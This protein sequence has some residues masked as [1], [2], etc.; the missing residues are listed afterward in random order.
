MARE[1]LRGAVRDLHDR[2]NRVLREQ[3]IQTLTEKLKSR[4]RV[5]GLD[6]ADLLD[7]ELNGA[8]SRTTI[9][10]LGALLVSDER[11]SLAAKMVDGVI[12]RYLEANPE[13]VEEE[14]A[15]L[16]VQEPD[17]CDVARDAAIEASL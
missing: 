8:R 12:S 17:P 14:V 15:E 13:V 11:E 3:A 9:A 4:G 10:E 1:I 16:E 5:N 6:F 7:E 2:A